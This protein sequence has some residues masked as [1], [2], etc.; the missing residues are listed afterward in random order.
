MFAIL[1]RIQTH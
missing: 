1:K